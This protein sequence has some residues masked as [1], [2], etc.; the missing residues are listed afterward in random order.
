MVYQVAEGLQF[1]EVIVVRQLQLHKLLLV[2]V[3]GFVDDVDDGLVPGMSE[4][5]VYP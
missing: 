3:V 5:C 2:H 4:V 1:G